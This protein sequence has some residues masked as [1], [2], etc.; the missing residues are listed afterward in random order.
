MN[1]VF[2]SEQFNVEYKKDDNIVLVVLKG[3][4]TRDNYRTPMM[5]AADMGLRHSC[6]VMAVEFLANPEL[7]EKDLNWSKKVLFANLKKSGLETLALIDNNDLEIVQA[8]RVFCGNK[9]KTIVCKSYEEVKRRTDPSASDVDSKYAS[10]TREQALEYLGLSKDADIKEID[11]RFWQMSKK[12]RGKDDPESKAMEDEISAVYDIASGRRDVRVK[13]EEQRQNEP[14]YFGRYVS[15]WKTII[16]Y[17]WKNWLLGGVVGISIIVILV[18]YLLNS[19]YECSV[20]VFGHMYLDNTYMREAL[21]DQGLKNPY[22]GLADVVVPND[23]NIPL[24]EMGNESFNAQFYTNPD[25]LISDSKAYL[26][27]FN[28]F[29]DIGPLYDQIMAGLSDEAKAGVKPIYMSER[30]SVRYKN[31]MYLEYGLGDEDI[32]NPAE[33]SDDPVLIGFEITD[34]D[35][36]TNFGIEAKWKSRQTTLLVGQCINSTNDEQTVKMMTAIINAA[37]AKEM[38]E[39]T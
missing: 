30:E 1:E 37:Y 10:M 28:V 36:V 16:H 14:K 33:F 27:Y 5:H 4:A 31:D 12:F 29:K 11:D 35:V 25:V 15:D 17:N 18:G 26:Y 8:I 9:F 24:D 23:E 2:D 39:S 13:E 7:S 22:V 20:L 6:K 34:Q 21:E 32:R 38:P 3:K 19:N